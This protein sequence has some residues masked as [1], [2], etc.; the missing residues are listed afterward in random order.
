[1]A[2][3]PRGALPPQNRPR[4]PPTRAQ[5]TE[6]RVEGSEH[7]CNAAHLHGCNKVLHAGAGQEAAPPRPLPL[8]LHRLAPVVGLVHVLALQARS[9]QHA[10][11]VTTRPEA[12]AAAGGQAAEGACLPASAAPV[13][14]CAAQT[15]ANEL[16]K[17]A[18]RAIVQIRPQ[19]CPGSCQTSAVHP[20][21]AFAA[22][23]P[24]GLAEP[25]IG[26]PDPLL[27]WQS[28]WHNACLENWVLVVLCSGL[29]QDARGHIKVAVQRRLG[30]AA[31]W[32]AGQHAVHP[33]RGTAS[34]RG[35]AAGFQGVQSSAE[36]RL[37]LLR[38]EHGPE[39]CSWPSPAHPHV[40]CCFADCLGLGLGLAPCCCSGCCTGCC[41]CDLGLP[42]AACCGGFA[43]APCCGFFPAA[44]A[45]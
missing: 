6:K 34:R 36:P 22:V 13:D 18:S 11:D 7:R 32:H 2:A 24:A 25:G 42:L 10:A 35:R 19:T 3:L 17:K 26:K 14:L 12:G 16:T 15:Q 1:M 29:R 37:E 33:A 40:D 43:L 31:H 45:P 8:A 41:C 5:C 20:A 4:I 9:T 21:G 28:A 38:C 27:C 23:V 30:Q 39:A 44:A